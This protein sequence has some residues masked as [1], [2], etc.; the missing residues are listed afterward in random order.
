[1]AYGAI[2]VTTGATRIVLANPR[3]QSVI[4]TNTD[5]TNKLYLGSD[6]AVTTS[7]GIEIGTGSNLTEDNGGS[8]IYCGDI[9]GISTGTVSVRFWERQEGG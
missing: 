5:A 4:I 7:S 9:W 8:K 3:R 2:T 1:M 6:N